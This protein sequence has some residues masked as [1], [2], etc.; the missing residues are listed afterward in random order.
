MFYPLLTLGAEQLFRVLEA[1]VSLRCHVLSAPSQVR[2]F[3]R[4]IDWLTS[5]KLITP[6]EQER[7][8]AMRKL[9]NLGSYPT[10]QAI[11][12][13]GMTLTVLGST[14]ELINMLFLQGTVSP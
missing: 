2:T 10:E 14:V 3:A 6:E 7:W 9:R 13:V 12:S 11:F 4:K 8:H 5:Q 1:A